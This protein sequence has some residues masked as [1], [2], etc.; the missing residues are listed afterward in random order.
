MRPDEC[1]WRLEKI[2]RSQSERNTRRRRGSTL[3]NL[4]YRIRPVSLIIFLN[5]LIYLQTETFALQGLRTHVSNVSDEQTRNTSSVCLIHTQTQNIGLNPATDIS[6]LQVYDE[7]GQKEAAYL[8]L[9][10]F[11]ASS[12]IRSFSSRGFNSDQTFSFL[13]HDKRSDSVW[14]IRT[15]KTNHNK[16]PETFLKKTKFRVHTKFVSLWIS[17]KTTRF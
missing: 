12:F 3:T 2:S 7:P 9:E 15:W 1:V 4:Y 17:L 14:K 8:S 10:C 11:S 5:H 6:S 13:S 16:P